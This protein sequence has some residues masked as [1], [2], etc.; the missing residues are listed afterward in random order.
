[1]SSLKTVPDEIGN[2]HQSFDTVT[3]LIGNHLLQ[4]KSKYKIDRQIMLPVHVDCKN[5]RWW[6]KIPDHK[7]SYI[8]KF[9]ILLISDDWGFLRYMR[10]RLNL[11][12]YQNIYTKKCFSFS[13][14]FLQE[15]PSKLFNTVLNTSG[16]LIFSRLYSIKKKTKTRL[17]KSF[18]GKGGVCQ[19][20]YVSATDACAHNNLHQMKKLIHAWMHKT[21]TSYCRGWFIGGFKKLDLLN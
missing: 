2:D 4:A 10:T 19:F 21:L 20:L 5:P 11:R 15:P 14:T 12:E 7:L 16:L 18:I 6:R 8:V 3:D 13:L 17:T 1:M 9:Q